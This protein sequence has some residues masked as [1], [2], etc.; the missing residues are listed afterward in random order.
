MTSEERQKALQIIEEIQRE[1]GCGPILM[2]VGIVNSKGCVENDVLFLHE[3]APIIIASL[4]EAGFS[5]HMS[6]KRL[7]V[8]C[9]K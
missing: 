4:V 3:A 9:F 8:L 6:N 2:E 1:R 7:A 5:F